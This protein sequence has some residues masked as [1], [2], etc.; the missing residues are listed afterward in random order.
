MVSKIIWTLIFILAFPLILY[1]GDGSKGVEELRKT[2]DYELQRVRYIPPIHSNAPVDR[3]SLVGELSKLDVGF[4]P[5]ITRL[6]G[7]VSLNLGI[8]VS[9]DR[10]YIRFTGR[11]FF[12]SVGNVSTFNFGR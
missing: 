9:A 12:S 4:R 6:P 3:R 2:I 1:G 5:V 7:G 11:P 8:S 10:R